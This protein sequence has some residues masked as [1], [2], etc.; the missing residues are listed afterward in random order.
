MSHTQNG[1]LR[2]K[3]KELDAE[4]LKAWDRVAEAQGAANR[5]RRRLLGVGLYA[6]LVTVGLV[7]DVV[8]R[9]IAHH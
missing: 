4:A 1:A 7:V 5:E 2:R 8:H 3:V 9:A 6:A